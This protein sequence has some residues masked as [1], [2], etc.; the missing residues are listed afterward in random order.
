MLPHPPAPSL[1]GRRGDSS[2]SPTAASR[3]R[4]IALAICRE[5]AAAAGF[6][7]AGGLALGGGGAINGQPLEQVGGMARN[8]VA[9]LDA[10]A[11]AL[12]RGQAAPP[13]AITLLRQPLMP[14]GLYR[15]AGNAGWLMTARQNGTL[16]RLG[17][18]PLR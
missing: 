10:T 12:A 15:L 6:T 17:A 16:R 4:N 11:D 2:P 3:R 7:W 1:G 9:A 8:V 13:E 18:R 14:R 5:F